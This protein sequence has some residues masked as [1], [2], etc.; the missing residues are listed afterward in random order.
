MKKLVYHTF[1][2]DLQANRDILS[3]G[4]PDPK[5]VY[6]GAALDR[7][8]DAAREKLPKG[9]HFGSAEE[10]AGG[11][12]NVFVRNYREVVIGVITVRGW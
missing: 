10:Y 8:K 6:T 7:H 12:M 4:L 3:N 2:K 1:T 9:C 11:I 5:P